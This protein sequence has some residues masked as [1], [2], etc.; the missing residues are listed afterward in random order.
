MSSPARFVFS[1]AILFIVPSISN[2]CIPIHAQPAAFLAFSITSSFTAMAIFLRLT[3]IVFHDQAY[4]FLAIVIP[5]FFPTNAILSVA[6]SL[7]VPMI[8]KFFT[9]VSIVSTAFCTIATLL[10][11]IMA[12][13]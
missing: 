1:K 7:N 8:F 4:W 6:I 9:P 10:Y 2:F 5:S 3:P 11:A 12:N 13:L